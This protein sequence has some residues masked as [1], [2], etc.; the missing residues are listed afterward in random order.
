MAGNNDM[1]LDEEMIDRYEDDGAGYGGGEESGNDD[2]GEDFRYGEEEFGYG[3]EE[4]VVTSQY[5]TLLS[6]VV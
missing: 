5:S 1:G 2:G 3:G 4:A 6:E